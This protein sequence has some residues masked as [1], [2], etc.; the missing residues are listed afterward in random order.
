MSLDSAILLPEDS[1][2][3]ASGGAYSDTL[4]MPMHVPFGQALQA[5]DEQ[6]L[7]EPC[8]QMQGWLVVGGEEPPLVRA[9]R[10][11]AA[12]GVTPAA[13]RRASAPAIPA[14]AFGN[15]PVVWTHTPRD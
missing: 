10:P 2:P 6:G 8:T 4:H 3:T 14:G 12:G 9:P 7:E 15:S 11:R 13:A 1:S 5:H